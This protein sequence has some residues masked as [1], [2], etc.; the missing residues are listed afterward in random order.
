VAA[1]DLINMGLRLPQFEF[2]GILY[3]QTEA[4]AILV[5]TA[6][7]FD[8]LPDLRIRDLTREDTHGSVP[9][10]HFMDVRVLSMKA[11]VLSDYGLSVET[12]I[13]AIKSSTVPQNQETRL[14]FAMPG[15][16]DKRYCLAKCS[17][18]VI[19]S[20][21]DR[22][23]GRAIASIEWRA[24]DPH[25]YSLTQQSVTQQIP[26]GS[27]T[28]TMTVTPGGTTDTPPI[29]TVTGPATNVRIGISSQ[30]PANDGTRYDNR[31][32]TVNGT[33]TAYAVI[34]VDINLATGDTLV[35]DRVAK[36][37]V[38][39]PFG[40]APANAYG[41]LRYDNRWWSLLPG[42]NVIT[43][44]VGGAAGTGAK[45]QVTWNDAWA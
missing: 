19:P 13:R 27:F 23:L 16:S 31:Q 45:L 24:T 14:V 32:T 6:T 44:S 2:N 26:N 36:T 4:T 25:F 7:G 35:I 9:Y 38:Y 22:A 28:E 8:D 43:F 10:P 37:M 11:S 29:F 17:K 33:T 12:I 3:G 21:Y 15:Y 1:G 18:R 40:G 30:V 39:T 41:N 20:D 34:A 5:E 42:T